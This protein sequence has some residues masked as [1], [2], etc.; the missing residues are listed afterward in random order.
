MNVEDEI[1]LRLVIEQHVKR[2][3]AELV[4][5]HEAGLR[6]Q[7][8]N[9]PV[10]RKGGAD[11]Y[12]HGARDMTTKKPLLRVVSSLFHFS[13]GK[14]ID[15]QHEHLTGNYTSLLGDCTGLSGDCSGLWGNCSGLTGDCSGL[16]GYCSGLT[17][18]CTGL[19]GDLS[20]IP[21]DQRPCNISEWVQ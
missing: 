20:E 12:F 10:M 19:R 2:L 5:A 6:P 13:D 17:G 21:M 8:R 16:R 3:N 18:D 9:T 15:G 14:R 4:K 7:I 1:S 11:I